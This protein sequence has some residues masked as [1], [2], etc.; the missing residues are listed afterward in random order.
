MCTSSTGF[1]IEELGR[2]VAIA[3]SSAG[4]NFVLYSALVLMGMWPVAAVALSTVCL[5]FYSFA[6]YR[7]F[8]FRVR[9]DHI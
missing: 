4:L 1:E 9:A 5:M 7:R 8:A 6:T 3:L 2:Y